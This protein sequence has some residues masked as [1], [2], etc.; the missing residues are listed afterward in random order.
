MKV[1]KLPTSLSGAIP[2]VSDCDLCLPEHCQLR[3]GR[4]CLTYDL[5][6]Q[7]TTLKALLFAKHGIDCT[8]TEFRLSRL[9]TG[10][11]T[12]VG[13]CHIKCPYCD[14]R[15]LP[16]FRKPYVTKD[17]ELQ[18]SWVFFCPRCWDFITTADLDDY[19]NKFLNQRRWVKPAEKL[20]QI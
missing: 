10:G 20:F 13:V 7:K 3:Y 1:K 19:S 17:D 11:W 15:P 12:S 6:P 4:S 9:T 18:K 2:P 5:L 16:A 14:H 8:E